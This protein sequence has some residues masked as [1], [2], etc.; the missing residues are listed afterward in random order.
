MTKKKVKTVKPAHIGGQ[1]YSRRKEEEKGIGGVW[2]V[3]FTLLRKAKQT[4]KRRKLRK[5]ANMT[6]G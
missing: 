6:P 3:K 1:Y 4:L 5:V 2:S